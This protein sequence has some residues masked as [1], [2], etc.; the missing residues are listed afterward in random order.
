MKARRGS[1]VPSTGHSGPT[2]RENEHGIQG[3]PAWCW[4]VWGAQVQG[5][6][7]VREGV[8]WRVGRARGISLC[9]GSGKIRHLLVFSSP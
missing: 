1:E 3:S 6:K 9:Y 7:S 5:Q 8:G 4:A 2:S